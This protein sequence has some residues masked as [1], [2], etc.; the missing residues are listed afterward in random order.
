LIQNVP[1]ENGFILGVLRGIEVRAINYITWY[2]IS[3]ICSIF[4][5]HWKV[6]Q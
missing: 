6:I 1:R 5:I 3:Q 2:L 4:K